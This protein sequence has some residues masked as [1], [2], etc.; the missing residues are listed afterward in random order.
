[1]IGVEIRVGQERREATSEVD[2]VSTTSLGRISIPRSPNLSSQSRGHMWNN[3]GSH[4]G[5]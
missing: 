1:M 5:W 3:I 2:E 4:Q